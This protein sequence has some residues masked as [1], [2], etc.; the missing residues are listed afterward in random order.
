MGK[1][2]VFDPLLSANAKRSCASC[3]RPEKAFCDQRTTSRGFLFSDNL[4]RNAPSLINAALSE[5]HFFHEGQH[6]NL[7]GVFEAVITNPKEFNFSYPQ[8]L[9][10]LQTSAEYRAL[11][12]SAFDKK[13]TVFNPI[14]RSEL[15]E[16]LIEYLKILRGYDSAFDKTMNNKPTRSTET[17][18]IN[19]SCRK[20]NAAVATRRQVLAA[21]KSPFLI[22]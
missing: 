6:Q 10:R 2:L 9:A 7:A 16:S 14:S 3:H 19:Y 5:T 17:W 15:D 11:F 13:N 21:V 12:Q 22:A 20:P 18:A 8:I 4:N 1:I